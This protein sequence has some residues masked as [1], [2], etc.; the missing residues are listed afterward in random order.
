MWGIAATA[1]IGRLIGCCLWYQIV[2]VRGLWQPRILGGWPGVSCGTSLWMAGYCGD[3]GH[4]AVDRR[5]LVYQ[6]G[7]QFSLVDGFSHFDQSR[8]PVLLYYDTGY[9]D[10]LLVWVAPLECCSI[11]SF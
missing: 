7:Y 1:D 3:H 6:I 2:D 5:L 11:R 10:T 4:W 8:D 9:C